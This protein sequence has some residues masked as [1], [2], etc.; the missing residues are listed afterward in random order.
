MADGMHASGAAEAGAV[1]AVEGRGLTYRFRDGGG[2]SGLDLLVPRGAV[3]ALLGANGSGKTTTIRMLLGLLRPQAGSLRVLGC[4]DP[5]RSADV[6]RAVGALVEAPSL[7]PHLSGR[8]NLEVTAKLLG[9][10]R[11]KID[12]VLAEVG[13]DVRDRDRKVRDYSLGMKQRLGLALALV[14]DPE[15]L[16]LDE[17]GNGLDPGGMLQLRGTVGAL[18]R[19]RGLTVLLSSH[20]LGEV[21]QLASHV[22]IIEAGT[23]RFQGR[24]DEL[25]P[26]S[27]GEL[28]IRSV[29]PDI[30][31][32]RLRELA[33]PASAAGGDAI[34]IQLAGT[35]AGDE[36]DGELLRR[37]VAGGVPFHAFQ[38]RR[39]TLESRYFE[40]IAGGGR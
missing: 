26:A 28:E 13:L 39:P 4:A 23:L 6:R 19:D 16:V 15:L 9:V 25:V 32:A 31:L 2:V 24:L 36:G 27:G 12:Q 8:A 11:P 20:L 10:P 14:G 30:A 29:N 34:R 5:A 1:P 35:G 3:Y 22:G 37:L 17:P 21:E 38:R 7:Y 18:A 33:L 40:L